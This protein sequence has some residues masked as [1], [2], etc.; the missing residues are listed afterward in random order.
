[1]SIAYLGPPGSFTQAAL[2]GLGVPPDQA[3]PYPTVRQALDAVR[4]GDASAAVVPWENS[5]E[6]SVTE[7]VDA[8]TSGRDL[9]IVG[10]TL[11]RVQFALGIPTG[12]PDTPGSTPD[13]APDGAPAWLGSVR[14]VL[15]HPIAH[16]QCRTWLGANLPRA[17]V[18]TTASTAQ[19]AKEVGTAATPGAA[20]IASPNTLRR[21][22]LRIVA[23][24]IGDRHD[25]VTRFVKVTRPAAATDA[26]PTGV[27]RTSLVVPLADKMQHL[28]TV[29][30]EFARSQVPL[31]AV[32]SRPGGCGLGTYS[33]LLECEGHI[34]DP[35]VG[36]VVA[37]LTRHHSAYLLGSYPRADL[38]RLALSR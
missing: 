25:A 8:L 12:T 29:L 21:Y 9:R 19:A 30:Q 11:L 18:V 37:S 3:V 33:F 27:D 35:G 28:H 16:A 1:M 4:A 32:L 20:A 38:G 24:D 34:D 23:D 13:G 17:D 31:T 2:S 5:V 36:V 14:Q 10:E 26:P 7:S 22:G 15:T 6:G